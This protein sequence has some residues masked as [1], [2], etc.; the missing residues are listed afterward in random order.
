MG[1]R[2]PLQTLDDLEGVDVDLVGTFATATASPRVVI[3]QVDNPDHD[4]SGPLDVVDATVGRVL[5]QSSAGDVDGELSLTTSQLQRRLLLSSGS[6]RGA[7]TSDVIGPYLAMT[8]AKTEAAPG[9]ARAA[10]F[11]NVDY[12]GVDGDLRASRVLATGDNYT[13]VSAAPVADTDNVTR[14]SSTI[15]RY[16]VRQG[17]VTYTFRLTR[18]SWAANQRIFVFGGLKP[19]ENM[20]FWSGGNEIVLRASDGLLYLPFSGTVGIQGTVTWPVA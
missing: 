19:S 4:G 7:S 17:E 3:E 11:G 16:T 2:N 18:A 8:N 5:L 15:S 10:A 13:Y 1:F 20:T 12:L 6:Y 14:W 9:Y